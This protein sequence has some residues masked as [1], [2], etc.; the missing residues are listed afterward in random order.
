MERSVAIFCVSEETK[1]RPCIVAAR[2]LERAA[3]QATILEGGA[4][5]YTS[6]IYNMCG[7]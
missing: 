6:K 2:N 7:W 5:K 4:Q 3:Q 1:G